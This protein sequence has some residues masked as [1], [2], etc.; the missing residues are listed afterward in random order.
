MRQ[1]LRVQQ[2][3]TSLSSSRIRFYPKSQLLVLLLVV[4][5]ALSASAQ[6]PRS[7]PEEIEWTWE[8]RPPHPVAILPNVLLLG[9]SISR[10]YFSE[11]AKDL[12]GVANVYLMASSTSIGDPRLPHQIAEF[13][14]LEHARF[15]VVHFNNGMHGWDYSEAQYKKAFPRFLRAVRSLS[16]KNGTL[17]WAGTTPIRPGANNGA[18]NPR[19]EERNAIALALVKPAGVLIDDQHALMIQHGDLH[20]DDVH[21]NAVG[22]RIQGDQAASI[23]RSA[24]APLP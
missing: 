4:A 7:I 9:D 18:S 20:E 21:F 23:I 16:D 1:R 3:K 24:L 6:Q 22:A 8:V 14:T 15:R 17:I 12:E 19:I 5:G 13:A 11:V 10:N 2:R